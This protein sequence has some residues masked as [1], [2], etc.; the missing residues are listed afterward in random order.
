MLDLA[1][2][3]HKTRTEL[4][5]SVACGFGAGLE[6]TRGLPRPEPRRREP[7]RQQT[8][9]PWRIFFPRV[10][11]TGLLS[12]PPPS[13]PYIARAWRGA[14]PVG[15]T[16]RM[17]A[18]SPARGGGSR[19]PTRRMPKACPTQRGTPRRPRPTNRWQFSVATPGPCNAALLP[20]SCPAKAHGARVR[21]QFLLANP[22]PRRWEM[23][24]LNVALPRAD[25]RSNRQL[26]A[27]AHS[28][29]RLRT[30]PPPAARTTILK[31][32]NWKTNNDS[33]S[34]PPAEQMKTGS[35]ANQRT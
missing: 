4:S 17:L 8:R 30:A 20:K 24:S 19:T 18:P 2:P 35:A 15:R 6:L 12:A 11:G 29:P 33:P 16:R 22:A 3:S 27:S 13:K 26:P 23:L 1:R 7:Y 14:V 10:D 31:Q 34:S 25:V 32:G 9:Q 28:V 5:Q 21:V